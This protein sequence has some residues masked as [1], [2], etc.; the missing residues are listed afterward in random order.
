MAA[1]RGPGHAGFRRRPF[2]AAPR[3]QQHEPAL[4]PSAV[5]MAG[6]VVFLTPVFFSVQGRHI[7]PWPVAEPAGCQRLQCAGRGELSGAAQGRGADEHPS[8]DADVGT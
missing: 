3:P 6:G 8:H 1:R 4:P 2:S 5:R 7:P